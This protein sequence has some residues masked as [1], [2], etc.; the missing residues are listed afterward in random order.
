MQIEEVYPPSLQLNF[1]SSDHPSLRKVMVITN[2]MD[3]SSHSMDTREDTIKR[4]MTMIVLVHIH[5]ARK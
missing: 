2:R 4:K 5:F 1:L 3:I